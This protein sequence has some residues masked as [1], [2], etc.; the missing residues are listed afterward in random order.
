MLILSAT[1]LYLNSEDELTFTYDY[2]SRYKY[3]HFHFQIAAERKYFTKQNFIRR[4]IRTVED[5]SGPIK[6]AT[7]LP[8]SIN[9]IRFSI[10]G[11][12]ML[13]WAQNLDDSVRTHRSVFRVKIKTLYCI[14]HRSVIM[15]LSQD[16]IKTRMMKKWSLFLF[17][18]LFIFRYLC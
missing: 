16:L 11:Y 7:T 18:Y 1:C 15:Y 17:Y 6:T 13:I 5:K 9:K 12:K 2:M 14:R 4:T 3:S 8:T 10:Y